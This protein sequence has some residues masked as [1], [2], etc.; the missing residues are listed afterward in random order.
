MTMHHLL[1]TLLFVLCAATANAQF[2]VTPISVQYVTNGAYVQARCSY[3]LPPER[4]YVGEQVDASGRRIRI[5][6]LAQLTT[7]GGTVTHHFQVQS[8]VVQPVTA[9]TLYRIVDVTGASASR[10]AE[11]RD[12]PCSIYPPGET[13]GPVGV[14]AYKTTTSKGVFS[15][16][17]ERKF[18]EWFLLEEF[19]GG[20]WSPARWVPIGGKSSFVLGQRY[21]GTNPPP[22]WRVSTWKTGAAP[23]PTLPPL[24]PGFVP[25][26]PLPP[27]PAP[28]VFAP[29]SSPLTATET[30]IVDWYHDK[31]NGLFYAWAW[32]RARHEIVFEDADTPQGPW[33]ERASWGCYGADQLMVAVFNGSMEKRFVRAR[34]VPCAA[35]FTVASSDLFSGENILA[36]TRSGLKAIIRLIAPNMR[37]APGWTL[38]TAAHQ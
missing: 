22:P 4:T 21:I 31:T 3:V 20:L 9:L 24:P 28:Q 15:L 27:V 32:Q 13:L 36:P 25:T 35:G 29:S 8:S 5:V 7:G 26:E 10:V 18:G 16:T 12:I 34:L 23:S 2:V 30:N 6:G 1:P 33:T 38:Y 14:P 19:R 37:L 11:L 17:A